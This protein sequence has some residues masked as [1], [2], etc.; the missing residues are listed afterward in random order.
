[1]T[2]IP[3]KRLAYLIACWPEARSVEGYAIQ[4]PEPW[5]DIRLCVRRDGARWAVDHYATGW[6]TGVSGPTRQ[7]AALCALLALQPNGERRA[8]QWRAADEQSAR[9]ENIRAE[10]SA[11]LREARKS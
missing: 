6:S 8:R 11:V 9:L 5:S 4:L 10:V 3:M 7:K 1:V 2:T